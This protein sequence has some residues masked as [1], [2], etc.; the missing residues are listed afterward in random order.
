[1]GYDLIGENKGAVVNLGYPHA[2]A[3]K[4]VLTE[5]TGEEVD[6]L[7][8]VPEEQCRIW[9]DIL[10]ANLSRIKLIEGV[11]KKI[12][13]KGLKY[14]FLVV[15]GADIKREFTTG[16]YKN[17]AIDFEPSWELTKPLDGDWKIVVDAFIEFLDS[18]RGIVK[19]V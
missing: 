2:F 6:F 13:R 12:G 14:G 18:C 15:Q 10:K 8:P 16:Y 7:H 4:V 11:N 19:A 17:D 3:L 5:L 9:A 1:M